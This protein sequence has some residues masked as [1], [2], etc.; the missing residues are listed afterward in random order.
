MIL[1]FQILVVALTPKFFN[2]G[3]FSGL[4]ATT[5]QEQII[6]A[7]PLLL[8]PAW[9]TI[10][11]AI[12]ESYVATI[13]QHSTGSL[14]IIGICVPSPAQVCGTPSVGVGTGTAA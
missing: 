2:N 10:A 7:S 13:E 3:D 6:A 8:G 9:P 11:T 5:I 1:R 14:T 12:S 4:V